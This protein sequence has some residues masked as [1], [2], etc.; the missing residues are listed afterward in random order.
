MRIAVIGSGIGGLSCA[1]ELLD[2]GDDP[3]VFEA[4]DRVGGSCSSRQTAV[5]VFDDAAQ[6]FPTTTD[7]AS[8]VPQRQGEFAIVHAWTASDTWPEHD[9]DEDLIPALT[10]IGLVGVPSVGALPAAIARPLDVRLSTPIRQVQR[11]GDDWILA[12]DSG[13]IAES[14]AAVVLAIPAP[15]ALPLA[16]HSALI[17]AALAQASYRSRWVLLVGTHRKILLP[18]YREYQGSPVERVAAIA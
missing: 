3:V 6:F 14:F 1:R 12:S 13:E 2:W 15:L 5:G 10:T 7:I 17:G 8:L 18:A 9:D 4:N 11:R 16:Q